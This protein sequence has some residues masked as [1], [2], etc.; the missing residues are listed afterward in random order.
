[1]A[2][3][4]DHARHLLRKCTHEMQDMLKEWDNLQRAQKT[5]SVTYIRRDLEHVEEELGH[6][7]PRNAR[8]LLGSIFAVLVVHFLYNLMANYASA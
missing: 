7:E 2:E 3:Q 6:S 1:M 8:F 5:K 4:I